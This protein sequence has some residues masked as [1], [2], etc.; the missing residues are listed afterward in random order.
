MIRL[1]RITF[2]YSALA[3]AVSSAPAQISFT[4]AIALAQKSNPK[5]LSAQA[6][7]DKATAVI[8]Q[9]R[10]AYVP[11]IVFGIGVGPTPYGFPLG[12]PSLFNITSQSLVFSY[13]QRDYLRSAHAAFDAS[14]LT[15]KDA[16]QGVAEDTALTYLALNHDLQRHAALSEQQAFADHLVTIVQERL[17][18][19]QD[20]PIGL[21]QARLSAAQIR[22]ALLRAD[23]D[24]AADQTHLARLIG[25]PPQGLGTTADSIPP[26]N[27]PPAQEAS[28]LPLSPAILSSYAAAHAKRETAF[29]E[30][31]YL[32]RPQIVFSGQYSRFASFNNYQEYYLHFQQNNAAVGV[33]ITIPLYDVQHAAKAREAAAE[34]S[35]SEHEADVA[36]DQFFDGRQRVLHTAAE[37]SARAEIA[38]LDRQ[39]AQQNLDVLLVQLKSGSGNLSGVQMTP[40][41][42]QLSRIA[43]REKYLA[44]LD[45]DFQLDQTRINLM[46]QTGELDAWI[47]AAAHADPSLTVKP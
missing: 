46:R 10:D 13:A 44:V 6:D 26:F 11:N 23:D 43:E 35:H 4:T 34:A 15:L 21:T 45:A 33:Q 24:T 32:W 14:V 12:T 1:L 40:K 37:L 7:V 28:E 31:R 3:A 25:L 2:A 39:L 16:R 20:T 36:R 30:S 5:V 22:L 42:E 38:T 47:A 19:G 18:A 8:Q 17:D 29:A 27:A 9:L 41:D